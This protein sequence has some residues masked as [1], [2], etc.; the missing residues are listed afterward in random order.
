MNSHIEELLH[1][2]L[3][4]DYNAWLFW[5]EASTEEKEAQ[6]RRQKS[7]L[8]RALGSIGEATFISELAMVEP[9]TFSLGR[10]SYVA[11]HAYITGTVTMGDDCTVN[12]FTVIRG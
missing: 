9:T 8:S 1:D 4:M 12:V 2:P 5:R 10:D 11:A 3:A 6:I 7:I